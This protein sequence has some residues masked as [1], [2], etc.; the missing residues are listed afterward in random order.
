[1]TLNEALSDGVGNH[2]GEQGDGTDRV[3]VAGDWVLEVIG[4]CVGVQNSDHGNAEL[5]SFVDGEVLTNRVDHPDGARRL[6]EGPNTTEGLLQLGQLALLEQQFLLGETLSGVFVVDFLELFH[7]SQALGDGLEVG[8][9]TTQP[10]LVDVGL[11][12]AGR[13]L[14]HGL[15]SL[16]L[17]SHEKHSSAV[18]DGLLDEVIRLIDVGQRLLE[19]DDVNTAALGQDKALDFRVPATGLVSKVNASVQ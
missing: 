13:L 18:R 2:L 15:L 6:L 7:A 12:H 17:R 10:A 19:V 14:R 11:A 9:Q 8:Q 3:V 1:M 16:L 4:V 5:A